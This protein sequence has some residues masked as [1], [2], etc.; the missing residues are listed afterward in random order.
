MND[1]SEV[2]IR[3]QMLAYL[4]DLE[5]RT[6]AGKSFE[7]PP[8]ALLEKQFG[9]SSTPVRCAMYAFR[10]LRKARQAAIPDMSDAPKK[11]RE[12]AERFQRNLAKAT[13]LK[14]EAEVRKRVEDYIHERLQPAYNA[15]MGLYQRVIDGRKGV[16]K[17]AIYRQML[18]ALHPDQSMSPEKK[19][20]MFEIWQKLENVLVSAEEAPLPM[21]RMPLPK[22]VEPWQ[23]KAK[24]AS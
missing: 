1:E 15:R 9:T 23:A 5:A 19:R 21:P 17:R 14:L 24:K 4:F 3:D 18:A 11:W 13:A 2:D 16:M 12:Q 7:M 20:E 10:E 8:H 6:P 22:T